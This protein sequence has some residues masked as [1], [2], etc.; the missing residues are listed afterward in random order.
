[1]GYGADR[2]AGERMI[3]EVLLHGEEH[4]VSGKYLVG[5]LGLRDNRDLTRRI[6]QERRVGVPICATTNSD[7]PG[8]Y[9]AATPTEMEKY[10]DSLDRRLLNMQE[11]RNAC[12]ESLRRMT[13]QQP[14]GVDANGKQT[15]G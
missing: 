4:A 14:E 5:I 15:A 11:T 12:H 3:K 10:I 8:Y 7:N 2:G 1:M 6:A 9:L 13:E